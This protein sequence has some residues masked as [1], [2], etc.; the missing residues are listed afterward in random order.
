VEDLTGMKIHTSAAVFFTA[1][2][3]YLTCEIGDV[4][5]EVAIGQKKKTATPRHGGSFISFA[6][7]LI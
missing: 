3:E 1:V 4:I 7:N 6:G 5:G 2:L